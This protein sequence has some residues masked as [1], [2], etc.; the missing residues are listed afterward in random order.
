MKR[1]KKTG[2]AKVLTPGNCKTGD[3][4]NRNWKCRRVW[5]LDN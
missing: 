5:E 1:K 3:P 4:I 2:E